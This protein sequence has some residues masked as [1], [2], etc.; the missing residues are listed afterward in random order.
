MPLEKNIQKIKDFLLEKYGTNLAAILIFGSANTGHFIEGKSDIDHMIFLKKLDNL[1]LVKES[2][3]LFDNLKPY[4]FATQYLFTLEGIISHMTRNGRKGWSVYITIV[5]RDGSRVIYSTPE[6]ESLKEKLKENPPTIED[7]KKYIKE[8]DEFEFEGYFKEIESFNLTKSL[9]AH[10]RR[11]LQIINYLQTN[12]LI[13]DY[14]KCLKNIDVN[15]KEKEKL[16]R[17][18]NIY[19]ERKSLAKKDIDYYKNLAGEFTDK[20]MKCG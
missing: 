16:E 5:G 1:D 13:F 12:K 8:K 6:F 3:F 15:R 2:K 17:L 4:H 9:M 20:I 19:A 11:K 7:L 10:L 14:E 18:Y